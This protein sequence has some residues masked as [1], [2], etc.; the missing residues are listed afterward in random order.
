M[1]IINTAASV[2]KNIR[3]QNIL[4]MTII[5]GMIFAFLM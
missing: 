3:I 5:A 4:D 2:I 1:E